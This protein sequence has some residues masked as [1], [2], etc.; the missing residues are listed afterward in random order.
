MQGKVVFGTSFTLK[1]VSS[2]EALVCEL[3]WVRKGVRGLCWALP[4]LW[5]GEG[6][7]GAVRCTSVQ[8]SGGHTQAAALR[9]AWTCQLVTV[10]VPSVPRDGAPRGG[11]LVQRVA[12][13]VRDELC[14]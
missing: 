13:R 6:F 1:P 3:C 7:A 2:H 12:T 14:A 4:Q 9:A 8:S 11:L 5:A 10:R